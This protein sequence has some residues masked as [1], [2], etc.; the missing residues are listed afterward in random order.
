MP[1]LVYTGTQFQTSSCR[2]VATTEFLWE[3]FQTHMSV[4]A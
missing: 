4:L 1:G 2:V 3:A